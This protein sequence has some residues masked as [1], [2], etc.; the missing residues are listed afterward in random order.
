MKNL[1][2]KKAIDVVGSQSEL[3]RR[4]KVTPQAV[5]AWTK[6]RIPAE[7]VIPVEN[8]SGISR[9]ELRPDIYPNDDSN[10]PQAHHES[11]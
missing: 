5:Q 9:Y 8:E 11:V 4:L 1:S 6:K 7:W 3:A 2:L 10:P